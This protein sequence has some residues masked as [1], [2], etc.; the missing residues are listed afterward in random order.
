MKLSS[1][2]PGDVFA[3]Q[4]TFGQCPERFDSH[5]WE[6]ILLPLSRQM[7]RMLL[8]ILGHTGQK[9]QSISNAE[10]KPLRGRW[11]PAYC[12]LLHLRHTAIAQYILNVSDWTKYNEITPDLKM[13]PKPLLHGFLSSLDLGLVISTPS[14][15]HSAIW[16]SDTPS[17]LVSLMLCWK[18]PT[19]SDWCRTFPSLPSRE[20]NTWGAWRWWWQ[21]NDVMKTPFIKNV[22]IALYSS[23]LH[24]NPGRENLLYAF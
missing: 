7:S 15:E 17:P 6:V 12:L 22:L 5:K 20:W 11:H 2:Q 9:P 16:S 19:L 8:N 1:S 13:P 14:A 21:I 24:C 10:V 23:V 4:G 3:P 18:G